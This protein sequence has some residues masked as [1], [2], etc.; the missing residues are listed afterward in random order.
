MANYN[1]SHNYIITMS[2]APGVF[3]TSLSGGDQTN[4][5]QVTFTGG[6]GPP[7][8]VPGPSQTTPI[9][10]E[11][12][13]DPVADAVVKAWSDA[14]HQGIQV[15]VTV[16]VIPMSAA[17]TVRGDEPPVTFLECYRTS[18]N[19]VQPRKGA[20]EPTMLVLN[21]QPRTRG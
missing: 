8:V 3:W 4:D 6:F 14:Y 2:V 9:T 20:A 18:L 1:A 16:T 17:G 5:A 13:Y 11:K 12:P 10:L 15:P 7:A 19:T 21:L